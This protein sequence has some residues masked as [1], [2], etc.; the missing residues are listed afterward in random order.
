MAIKI[1]EYPILEFDECSEGFVKAKKNIRNPINLPKRVVISFF[2]DAVKKIVEQNNLELA[3][4]IIFE[5]LEVNVYLWINESGEQIGLMHGLAGGPYAAGQLEKLS[6]MGVD[7]IVV[8]GGC[9]VLVPNSN[10]G[11][12]FV[13]TCALRDE[14]TSYH[15]IKPSRF[16]YLNERIKNVGCE[17]LKKNN[18]PFKEVTTWTTDALYRET[19]DKIE[20]RKKDGCS[21]VEMECA[22]FMAVSQFKNMN[23]FQLLYAGDELSKAK[24]D[25]RNWKDQF[26]VRI[27][28]ILLSLQ[29]C[30][31][32]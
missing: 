23:F 32:L 3:G 15:Y 8:C 20:L 19:V 21:V 26:D 18:I 24:W 27:N 17:F 4:K 10:V 1:N 22:S 11:E 5:T 2:G 12:I 29:I 30:S 6:A 25:N 7:T 9:G 16:I 13:P 31:I 14:G 28:L